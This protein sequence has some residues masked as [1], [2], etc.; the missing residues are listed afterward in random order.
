M[1][2]E[3]DWKEEWVDRMGLIVT[4]SGEDRFAALEKFKS[5]MVKLG[6]GDRWSLQ[7]CLRHR[8]TPSNGQDGC[9]SATD[10]VKEATTLRA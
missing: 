2:I 3:R 5:D 8:F 6:K 1:K 10:A 4:L 9:Q 7:D